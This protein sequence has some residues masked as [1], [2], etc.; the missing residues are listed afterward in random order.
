M[1]GDSERIAKRM[2]AI[3]SE[4]WRRRVWRDARTVNVI[5]SA[6]R[7]ASPGIMLAALK[8][9]LGQDLVP[10]EAEVGAEDDD[11]DDAKAV[12]GPTKDDIYKAYHKACLRC[13]ALMATW[14]AFP[15]HDLWH[16][17][18][19]TAVWLVWQVQHHAPGRRPCSSL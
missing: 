10:E 4:L 19:A 14:A 11:E 7:H 5:A 13:I 18:S 6:T 16:L 3:L 17:T 8:F 9:F 2:L 15:L 1:Q 12:V